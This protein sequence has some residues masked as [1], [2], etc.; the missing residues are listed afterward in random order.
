ML[1]SGG[2]LLVIVIIVLSLSVAA[3]KLI[4]YIPFET[5]LSLVRTVDIDTPAVSTGITPDYL[6][7][8]ADDLS[9]QMNLPEGMVIS[10]SIVN[11]ETVNAFAT[12]G[13]NI[14]FFTGLLDI[15]PDENTLAMVMAH[16][17]AHIKLRHPLRALGRGVVVGVA[18]ATVAGV[19]GNDIVAKLVGDTSLLTTLNFSR[20]QESAADSLAVAALAKHYGHINGASQLFDVL[21]QGHEEGSYSTPEFLTTHPLNKNRTTALKVLAQQNGWPVNGN[22]SAIPERVR[23]DIKGLLTKLTTKNTDSKP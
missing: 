2:V 23:N 6:Q 1:L 10:I 19:A 5:E 21:H 22:V 14:V 18:I 16:E 8:L 9:Q 4:Q 11:S 15:I 3:D 12:L 20:D 7:A 17:I 13:G